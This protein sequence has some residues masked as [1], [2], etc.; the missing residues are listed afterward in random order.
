MESRH[1]RSL[2]V[3]I[4]WCPLTLALTATTGSAFGFDP[5]ASASANIS[6]AIPIISSDSVSGI[7]LTA[8]ATVGDGMGTAHATAS[9]GGS[10]S[11]SSSAFNGFIGN[12][13]SGSAGLSFS[14]GAAGLAPGLRLEGNLV[15]SV[16]GHVE[17][18]SEA[19]SSGSLSAATL[20][21]SLRSSGNGAS[22]SVGGSVSVSS[23]AGVPSSSNAGNGLT[24][25]AHSTAKVGIDLHPLGIAEVIEPTAADWFAWGIADPTQ[26]TMSLDQIGNL[27]GSWGRLA[28]DVAAAIL[29]KG[30]VSRLI[31][32]TDKVLDVGVDLGT[33]FEGQIR[34]PLTI[35]P[36]A[37]AFIG[38]VST[39][40]VA[41]KG[42]SASGTVTG[43]ASGSNGIG[44]AFTAFEVPY[45][46]PY[47]LTGVW[48]TIDGVGKVPVIRLPAVPEPSS[49]AL[50]LSGVLLVGRVACR[51]LKNHQEQQGIHDLHEC[52]Y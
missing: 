12:N 5:R 4:L 17:A 9:T 21:Y 48:M 38:T 32:A 27:N 39:S 52:A 40:S 50:L 25:T 36:G 46:T 49:S 18:N 45:D 15:A 3:S 6:G 19:G 28:V 11:A 13:H 10:F 2:T 31:P 43:T 33:T 44:M 22:D 14:F 37:G 47:D 23:K 34:V 51:R 8:F 24:G 42:A 35:G 30:I 20:R 16:S 1:Q 7:G 41:T 26:Q 29:A